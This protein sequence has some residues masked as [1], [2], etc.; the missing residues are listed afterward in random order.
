MAKKMVCGIMRDLDA[1]CAAW[2]K[3]HAE[4]TKAGEFHARNRIAQVCAR[5]ELEPDEFY[6]AA[7]KAQRLIANK[8]A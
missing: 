5:F 4:Y 1:E 7:Q 8:Q 6:T 2:N 3:R